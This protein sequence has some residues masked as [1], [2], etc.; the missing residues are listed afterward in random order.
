[1]GVDAHTGQPVGQPLTGH[2]GPVH[3]VAFGPDGTRIAAG[4][5]D[6]RIAAGG[7]DET[8]ISLTVDLWWPLT[9]ADTSGKSP[10]PG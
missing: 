9:R 4:G 2:T 1:M 6:T 8:V 3:S 10:R 5:D 7:D